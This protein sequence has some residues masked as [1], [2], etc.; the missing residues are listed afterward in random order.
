MW[1][2]LP[3]CALMLVF[4]AISWGD[5]KAPEQKTTVIRLKV[6]PMAAPKPALK[7]QLLPELRE[8]NPGNPVSGYLKCFMEQNHF[9]YN[10]QILEQREKWLKMPLRELPVA[11]LRD[12]GGAMAR[13]AD[14]AARLDKPDWQILQQLKRE[15]INVLLPDVQV[16]RRLVVVLKVRLRGAIA[17]RRFDDALVTAKTMFAI[18][19]HLGEHPTLVGE[20]VAITVTMVSLDSLEEMI[21]QPGCP[22]LFWALT[23]L[24]SPFIDLRNGVQGER[25]WMD[26]ELAGLKDREPMTETELQKI[27]ERL[28]KD[29]QPTKEDFSQLKT[30]LKDEEKLRAARKRLAEYGLPEEKLKDFPPLQVILL[31]EKREYEELRDADMK[32]MNLPYVQA[33]RVF[34]S[35]KR[36][37]SE[38]IFPNFIAAVAKVKQAQARL[39]QRIALLRCV[40]ALRLYA[41]DHDGKLPA[42]LEDIDLPLPADPATGKPVFYKVEGD[43]AHL[44]GARLI[45]QVRYEVTFIK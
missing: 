6:K 42:K 28:R 15:G 5:D 26:T 33:A 25:V 11:D 39:D 19:R 8:I 35:Q 32:V 30:R 12:Y 36:S 23:D 43:T 16:M 9:L 13:Q 21:Q 14:F 17:D 20:L 22:N 31:D 2:T 24:P 4:T 18:S 40:E 3:V 27:V 41:A 1:R 34:E 45:L 7:Y 29:L 38:M 37:K 44:E 10:K